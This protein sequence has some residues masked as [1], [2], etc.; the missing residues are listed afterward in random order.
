MK[1][2]QIETEMKLWNFVLIEKKQL[3]E[4]ELRLS[5]FFF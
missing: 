1:W 3:V 4:E 5:F 2:N